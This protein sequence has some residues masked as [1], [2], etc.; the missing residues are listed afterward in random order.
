MCLQSLIKKQIKL[1]KCPI[2]VAEVILHLKKFK[3]IVQSKWEQMIL[4]S[5]KTGIQSAVSSYIRIKHNTTINII[6]LDSIAHRVF[7]KFKHNFSRCISWRKHWVFYMVEVY[8]RRLKWLSFLTISPIY[9]YISWI[10]ENE[11]K[12]NFFFLFRY[13]ITFCFSWSGNISNKIAFPLL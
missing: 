13:L 6:I 1:L 3:N 7:D 12:N 10:M 5:W 8:I 11:F 9:N 4:S 2:K